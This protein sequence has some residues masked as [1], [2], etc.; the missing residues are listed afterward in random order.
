MTSLEIDWERWE[1]LIGERG[2]EID[3]R[4]GSD[5][6]SYPGWTYPLDY[7]F[8]PGTVAPDG[9]EIDVFCGTAQS[10][11]RA[12]LIVSHDGHTE[13]KLLWNVTDAE[14]EAAREFLAELSTTLIWREP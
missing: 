14:A 8:V 1:R 6:P 2:V 7:G 13:P 11:L 9:A 5:H 4:R 3:R 12:A 10:G